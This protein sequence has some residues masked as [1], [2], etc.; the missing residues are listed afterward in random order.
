MN[1]VNWTSVLQANK[2]ICGVEF[3]PIVVRL[4][5]GWPYVFR[6]CNRDDAG[7]IFTSTRIFNNMGMVRITVRGNPQSESCVF[8]IKFPVHNAS[9]M[10]LVA[11]GYGRFKI[12][13]SSTTIIILLC[14]KVVSGVTIVEERYSLRYQG[15]LQTVLVSRDMRWYNLDGRLALDGLLA[16]P[17]R[18]GRKQP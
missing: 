5:Q 8:Q 4:E 11:V 16:N 15:R 13:D 2:R 12:E 10:C 14:S 9:E 3:E 18:S 1:R 6:I 17:V 7:H